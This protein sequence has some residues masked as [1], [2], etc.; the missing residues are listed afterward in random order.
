MSFTVRKTGTDI[1]IECD[2]IEK[3]KDAAKL[4]SSLVAPSQGILKMEPQPESRKKQGKGQTKAWAIAD[5]W[6]NKWGMTRQDARNKIGSVRRESISK[7]HALRQEA[8]E[9]AEAKTT[10]KKTTKKTPV[11][12]RRG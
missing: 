8:I 2:T 12:R 6:A 4:L 10:E 9:A 7:W 1:E 3:T 5:Y 11:K